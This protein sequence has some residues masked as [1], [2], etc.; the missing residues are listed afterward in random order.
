VAG[1]EEPVVVNLRR[2]IEQA[3]RASRDSGS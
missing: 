1:P 2:Q 3:S